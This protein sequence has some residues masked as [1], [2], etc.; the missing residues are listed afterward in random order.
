MAKLRKA[1][2]AASEILPAKISHLPEAE[3]A[4]AKLNYQDQMKELI[5]TVDDLAVA[6]KAGKNKAA[7]GIIDELTLLEEAGHHKFRT[8]QK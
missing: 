3:Q 1:S 5:A 7:A 2:V 8:E 6:L 4:A